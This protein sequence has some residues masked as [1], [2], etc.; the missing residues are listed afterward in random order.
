MGHVFW[1]KIHL[2]KAR[3]LVRPCIHPEAT[4]DPGRTAWHSGRGAPGSLQEGHDIVVCAVSQLLSGT[5]S[6]LEAEMAGP[7]Q[8]EIDLLDMSMLYVYWISTDG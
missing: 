6:E 7:G 4:A 3:T 8:L 1:P 5:H 2:G